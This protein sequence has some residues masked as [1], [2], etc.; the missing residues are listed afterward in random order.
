MRAR[1]RWA[2]K[3]VRG[4]ARAQMLTMPLLWLGPAPSITSAL[5]VKI[6]SLSYSV[7]FGG[8]TLESRP[9]QMATGIGAQLIK[10]LETKW[11]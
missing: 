2:G 8:H 1:G 11:P 3:R 9:F 6:A 10:S 5:P 7:T 4:R